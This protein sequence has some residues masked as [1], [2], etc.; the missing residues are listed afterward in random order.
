[1]A[2]FYWLVVLI[3]VNLILWLI[4]VFL[5]LQQKRRQEFQE[6]VKKEMALVEREKRELET[7]IN[8]MAEGLYVLDKDEKFVLF[9][10]AAE[11]ILGRSSEEVIG[12]RENDILD[13][14]DKNK[15]PFCSPDHCDLN[16]HWLKGE[17]HTFPLV[18]FKTAKKEFVPVSL[19]ISPLY[20]DGGQPELGV[21]IFRDVTKELEVDRAKTE[22]VSVASHQLRTPLNSIR[23]ILELL[24]KGDLGKLN[25]KQG[26]F[27]EEGYN[28]VLRMGKLIDDLLNVSRIE[29]GKV[30][31]LKELINMKELFDEVV[32]ELLYLAKARNLKISNE[33]PANLTQVWGD[34]DRIRQVVQNLV[35]NAIKYTLTKGKVTLAANVRKDDVVFMVKDT[36]IGIPS[37]QQEKVFE[38]FF[39]AENASAVQTSGTGL[40]LY[41]AKQFVEAA[42]GKIWFESK[43]GKG[44]T[45]YFSL[46]IKK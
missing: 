26:E 8:S 1:M 38:K 9:N 13:S 40:G 41:V 20:S 7:V 22:F 10:R 19:T 46:S 36:G 34:H 43:E 6:L 30:E 39:R 25:N 31:L 21:F 12:K 37:H 27:L 4:V 33:I 14:R 2:N 18:Y 3:L 24:I 35:D 45:F 42:G 29:S 15:R 16:F 32:S 28:S 23:W 11:R 17:S 44:T 5:N